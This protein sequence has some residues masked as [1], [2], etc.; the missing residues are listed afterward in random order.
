MQIHKDKRYQEL[1]ER[2][3]DL[4]TKGCT[5]EMLQLLEQLQ[6]MSETE[7]DDIGLA[8]SYFYRDILSEDKPGSPLYMQYAKRALKIAETKNIPY[9]Q[10]KASNSLGIMYSEISDFYN[11]L[12]HYLCALRLAEKHPEFLYSSIVLNNIG[13]LFVW[14]KDYTDAAT[15]LERAYYESVVQNQDQRTVS[16]IIILNLIELYSNLENDQKVLQWQAHSHE[17]LNIEVKELIDCILLVHE[18]KQL[19]KIGNIHHTTRNIRQFIKLTHNIS[20]YIYIF[21]CYVNAL[22]LC[23]ELGDFTLSTALMEQL[24]HTQ[25]DSS[26]TSFAYDYATARTE[27]CLAFHEQIKTDCRSIYQE[28]FEQSQNRIKQ[29]HTTYAR[30]L[31]M[32]IAYDNLKDENQNVLLQNVLLQKNIELDLFTNLYNKTSTEKYV[33]VALQERPADIIQAL[34]LIDIDLF[35]QINDNYGHVFGDHIITQ[36]A[37]TLY[38]LDKGSKIAGRFGGDEFLVFLKQPHSVEAIKETAQTLLT[39][40]RINIKLP[41]QRIREITLSIGIC[42]IDSPIDFKEAFALADKALYYAKEHGRNQFMLSMASALH[43]Q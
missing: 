4:H 9:Y 19:I 39:Q 35:K 23:I 41:D 7:Q 2:M 28:Y 32:K 26:M 5:D 12:E 33:R 24:E 20:D 17:I 36:V 11:S 6:T 42:V 31:T 29:L 37:N 10:M 43:M 34:L 25:K 1:I 27:Y 18:A 3:E 8:V 21:H 38:E 30:S 22:K 15:Y 40:I 14:L 16:D 13:N